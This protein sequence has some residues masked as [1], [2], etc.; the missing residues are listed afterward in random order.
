MTTHDLIKIAILDAMQSIANQSEA[1]ISS[2]Q[3]LQAVKTSSATLKRHLEGLVTSGQI[4]R[5][6]KARATRYRMA[7][8][9]TKREISIAGRDSAPSSFTFPKS[10]AS[11]ALF[12]SL[13]QP[14]AARAPVTYSRE[15]VDEYIPNE[16]AL[17]PK[18]L[19]DSVARE[20]SMIGQTPAA[21]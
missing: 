7:L 21:T 13:T 5:S 3:L 16:T 4:I 1:G 2:T 9:Q 18:H 14:L 17:P 15:L 11:Q 8:L 10:A 20:G 12:I 6:G 19:A